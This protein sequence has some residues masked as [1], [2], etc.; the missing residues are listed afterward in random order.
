MKTSVC[1]LVLAFMATSSPATAQVNPAFADLARATEEARTIIQSE[2]KTIIGQGLSLST[3]EADRFWPIYDRY[4]ADMKAVGDLRVKVITDYAAS[5]PN[6]SDDVASQ[7]I[8]DS[9][10]YQ[11]KVFKIR[12]GYLRKFRKV[13]PET[14]VAR[15]YQIEN[16]LDAITS[17]VLADQITLVPQ[18]PNSRP[19]AAPAD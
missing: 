14:K 15:L 19:I 4:L 16:K 6:L 17:F 7:L 13:L 10:K 8:D 9:L 12:K 18:A 11:D 5:Y 2:R 1:A 3:E